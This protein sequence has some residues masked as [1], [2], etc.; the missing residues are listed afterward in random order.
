MAVTQLRGHDSH[1]NPVAVG[2]RDTDNVIV[3]FIDEG[4]L[5]WE[6]VYERDLAVTAG[7]YDD[8]MTAWKR[9]YGSEMV[10]KNDDGSFRAI[11]CPNPWAIAKEVCL[12]PQNVNAAAD[13][14]VEGFLFAARL[15]G[16]RRN[17]AL[18][19]A[20]HKLARG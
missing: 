7:R 4:G 8:A 18:I 1:G 16:D 13:S 2:D 10:A 9:E 3:G 5:A 20:I 19:A 11:V 6:S 12:N 17:A 14:A 15:R